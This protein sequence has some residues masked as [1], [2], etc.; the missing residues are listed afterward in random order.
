M[1]SEVESI[2]KAAKDKLAKL[3][4]IYLD[5]RPSPLK[6]LPTLTEQ[7]PTIPDQLFLIGIINDKRRNA[8][9]SRNSRI[10]RR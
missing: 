10:S 3:N 8:A 7:K 9:N 2:R 6:R 1:K 4:D 5:K